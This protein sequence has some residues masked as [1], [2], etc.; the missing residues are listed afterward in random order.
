MFHFKDPPFIAAPLPFF[1]SLVHRCHGGLAV[2]CCV[3]VEDPYVEKCTIVLVPPEPLYTHIQSCPIL[4]VRSPVLELF[5][6]ECLEI[7][8]H[9]NVAADLYKAVSSDIS[10][11]IMAG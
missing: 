8:L 6:S 7:W 11:V 3:W 4:G 10:D 1:M 2:A 9:G 5:S